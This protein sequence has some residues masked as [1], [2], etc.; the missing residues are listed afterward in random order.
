M[1]PES[2]VETWE[3]KEDEY[4]ASAVYEHMKLNEK[5]VWSQY[6]SPHVCNRIDDQT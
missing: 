5:L 3:D 2:Y 4:L 6:P 1:E